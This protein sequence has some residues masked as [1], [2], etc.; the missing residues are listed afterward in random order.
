MPVFKAFRKTGQLSNVVISLMVQIKTVP[1]V[2]IFEYGVN[3]NTTTMTLLSENT[4]DFSFN[5]PQAVCQHTAYSPS[6]PV[7]GR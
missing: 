6:L 2:L 3:V 5:Q 1:N 4:Q 7:I